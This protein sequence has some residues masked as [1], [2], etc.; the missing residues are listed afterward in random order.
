[1]INACL[2]FINSIEFKF[3]LFPNFARP[4]L[5]K[6]VLEPRESVANT[7][8][9]DQLKPV[10]PGS[11]LSAL[12][13]CNRLPVLDLREIFRQSLE[14]SIVACANDVLGGRFPSSLRRLPPGFSP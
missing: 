5:I 9:V 2:E 14:S 3:Y 7:G 13:G 1:M 10:G 6:D 12:I 4:A 11:V 8:D